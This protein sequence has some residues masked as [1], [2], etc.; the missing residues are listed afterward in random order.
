M[1]AQY[2]NIPPRCH[3]RQPK[4]PED[5][6][7]VSWEWRRRWLWKGRTGIFGYDTRRAGRPY[8]LDGRDRICPSYRRVNRNYG[9]QKAT[10][11]KIKYRVAR[12][13]RLSPTQHREYFLRSPKARYTYGPNRQCQADQMHGR[14][15]GPE[16]SH[17]RRGAMRRRTARR[18]RS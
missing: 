14:E 3:C 17:G 10:I 9:K 2:P 8:G 1:Q 18:L 7:S 15:N 11:P 6:V 4:V 13:S 5:S 16:E 12:L